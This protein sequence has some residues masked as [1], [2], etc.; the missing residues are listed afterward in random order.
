[1]RIYEAV[2]RAL[3]DVGV[4]AA[5]GGAGEGISG[6]MLALKHSARIRTVITRNEQAASFMACGYAMYSGK[7][8]FCFASAG[9]GAF[10]LF[11]GLAT[12]LAG[13]YP[14]LAVSG[15]ADRRFQGWGALN[16]T[17]GRGGTPDS[18]AMFA[19]TTKASFLIDDPGQVFDVLEE[20]VNL[21]FAGRPGPVHVHVPRDLDERGVKIRGAR[22]VRLDVAPVLPDPAQVEE[23]ARVLADAVAERRRVV[24][25]AG[26][27][28]VRSGAGP[29]IGRLVERFQFPLLTTLDGKG[30]VPERHPLAAGVFAD[31]GHSSAW[32][33]FREAD[34]VLCV[35]SSLGQHATF[36]YR[37][38]LFDGKVLLYVNIAEAEFHKAY[39]PDRTL[40]SDARPAVA[41]IT[42]ALERR[43]GEVP[44]ARVRGRDWDA[45][46]IVHVTDKIHP[47][48]L[49]REIGRM[50][51]PRAVLLADSG[52]HASWL[53][54]H[55]E[56]RDDQRFRKADAFG[57]M[58]AHVNGA[59]GVK[60]AHPDRTVVVGCGDGCYTMGGFELMT[61]VEH[62]IPVVWVVFNDHEYKLVKLA[63]L[64]EHQETA[65]V[66]FQNPDFAAYA[67]ACGAE[68]HTAE[69][70]ADFKDA[71]G[72]ALASSRPTLIDARI[73]RSPAP[74]YS[75]SPKGLI[76]GLTETLESRLH[77]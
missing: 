70:L 43:V 25:L 14:V 11:S 68:A 74:H 28:A 18:R 10:N 58:S 26:F 31:S 30:I 62:E 67:R 46:P 29:E 37:E 54:Y 6:L 24:V 71:F 75:P 12:A 27:G 65:L 55:A 77:D 39:K 5:F 41:A 61:A 9:P 33:A 22:P 36:D 15:Y 38:D 35:G 20:A 57:A 56:L 13:C 76:A 44:R 66:E 49:A 3:E 23:I 47:G 8:G 42:E 48:E 17:S 51:P 32:K 59:I 7:P 73:S 63:Q 4:D 19:A 69:T 1:M 53:G 16:E 34:V 72:T 52:A 40:L 21:A 64:F 50:L 45:W 2:V 60:L